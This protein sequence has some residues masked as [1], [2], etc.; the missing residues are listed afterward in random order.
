MSTQRS[1]TKRK[2]ESSEQAITSKHKKTKS[3][4]ETFDM[5]RMRI[6][7]KQENV[8]SK[9]QGIVYW[10]WRDQRVQGIRFSY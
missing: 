9:Y 4:G 8:L 3:S 5:K 2:A 1:S 7:T 10:M 6:L